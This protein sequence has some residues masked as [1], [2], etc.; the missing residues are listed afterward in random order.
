MS[1]IGKLPIPLPSG[2][3][4][5]LTGSHLQVKG[6]RGTLERSLSPQMTISVDGGVIVVTRPTDSTLH[7][8]Q[9]GLTRTLIANMV[10]GVSKGFTRD[11]DL[12]GVGYRAS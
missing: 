8:A 2:V 6:T 1:R 9:H 5:T 11:L 10:D 12:V 3:D 7:R 4:V